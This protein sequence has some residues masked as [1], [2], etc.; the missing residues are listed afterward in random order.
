MIGYHRCRR[1]VPAGQVPIRI[2]LGRRMIENCE[3]S[4]L[5]VGSIVELDCDCNKD[6][7]VYSAGRLVARGEAVVVDGKFAVR[8]REI[9]T[10]CQTNAA[11]AGAR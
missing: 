1:D 9:L 5:R 10:S 3:L 7:D 8:M 6:V 2:E 4:R 11:L